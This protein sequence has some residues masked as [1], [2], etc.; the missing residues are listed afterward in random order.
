M[1]NTADRKAASIVTVS[2]FLLYPSDSKYSPQLLVEEYLQYVISLMSETK[3][4]T[5]TRQLAK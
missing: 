3:F 2:V 5:H 1:A 4:Y